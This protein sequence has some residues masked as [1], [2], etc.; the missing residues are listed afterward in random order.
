VYDPAVLG[1]TGESIEQI[2]ARMV[3]FLRMVERRVP[4]G[5]IAAVGHADPLAALRAFLLNKP[6]V[7]ASLR[8]EAPPPAGLFR[9][10]FRSDGD[11]VME[12][13]WKPATGA[14][15]ES[16]QKSMTTTE[17]GRSAA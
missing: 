2:Q 4:N 17:D 5:V 14:D 7:V 15:Q 16:S 12:S 10:D 1:E 6:A 3:R 9:V 13:I 8:S 11:T